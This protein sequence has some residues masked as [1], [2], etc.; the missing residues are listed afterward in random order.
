[1]RSIKFGANTTSMTGI[2]GAIGCFLLRYGFI[3]FFYK[4]PIMQTNMNYV[5]RLR[6]A[7]FAMVAAQNGTTPVANAFS[8]PINCA[9]HVTPNTKIS[10]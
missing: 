4:P 8:K 5:P 1:M 6:R 9:S 7:N 3:P 10:A 2:F